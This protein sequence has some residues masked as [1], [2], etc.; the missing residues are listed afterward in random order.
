MVEKLTI[1]SLLKK[2]I[3]QLGE[4][5]YFNPL[6]DAQMLL[7]FLLDRDKL[8][9]YTHGKDEVEADVSEEFMELIEL[10][11]KRY[12]LQYIIGKQEFMGLDFKVREGVLVPRP[13]TEVLVEKIIEIVEAGHFGEQSSINIVD[14]GTGSGAITLSLAH[15]IKNANLYSV[16]ISDIP[17]EVAKENAKIHQLEDRV[18]FLKGSMLEPLYEKKLQGK[19]DILASNPPYIASKVIEELQIEVSTYEPKLA[20]DGGVD[21]LDFYREITDGVGDFLS[22]RAILA[23]EIG[24][25]QGQAVRNLLDETG[26]FKNIEIFTDLSGQDRVVIGQKG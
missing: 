5:D 22:E 9:I 17:L 8:Y 3:A 26:Q 18:C 4:G 10:R 16:D 13:D 12:P 2:G 23:F 1:N 19:V 25:D 6:L 24:Y 14:I 21:G 11:A 15:Y 7:M 20:L